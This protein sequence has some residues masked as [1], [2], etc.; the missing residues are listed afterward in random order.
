MGSRTQVL[1]AL[2]KTGASQQD[3]SKVQKGISQEKEAKNQNNSLPDSNNGF[4]PS[5]ES[6]ILSKAFANSSLKCSTISQM[7]EDSKD[8]TSSK[9]SV[10]ILEEKHSQSPSSLKVKIA[11]TGKP[12]ILESKSVSASK[13]RSNEIVWKV[14]PSTLPAG[15]KTRTLYWTDREKHFYLSPE[16]KIFTS[17]KSVV[18]FMEQCGTYSETDFDKV[19][20][21][22]NRKRKRKMK[23]NDQWVPVR[24]KSKRKATRSTAATSSVKKSNLVKEET[25][26]EIVDEAKSEEAM[27]EPSDS[28]LAS[29]KSCTVRI[30]KLDS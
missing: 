11:L 27:E 3:I 9:Q 8:E 18:L 22:M 5:K 20:K 23:N 16:G 6:P 21:G 28:K 24:K 15:W 7:G 2:I 10:K 1:E 30:E 14:C 4:H 12:T 26:E 17:R 13:G 29:I 19:K 25:E